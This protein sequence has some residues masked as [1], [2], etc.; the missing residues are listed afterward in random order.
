MVRTPTLLWTLLQRAAVITLEKP[1]ET[2]ATQTTQA[3]TPVKQTVNTRHST[4]P[5]AQRAED[6]RLF[7]ELSLQALREKGPMTVKGLCQYLDPAKYH[8]NEVHWILR[9]Y[10]RSGDL[11]REKKYD[12]EGEKLYFYGIN[13]EKDKG[14]KQTLPPRN[15]QRHAA[16]K[17][18]LNDGAQTLKTYGPD[19]KAALHPERKFG[20]L[21]GKIKTSPEFDAPMELVNSPGAGAADTGK[22]AGVSRVS[23]KVHAMLGGRLIETTMSDLRELYDDLKKIFGA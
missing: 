7:R 8:H 19:V 14:L 5:T 1:M 21:K 22:V 23:V 13:T 3:S 9:D 17:R 18:T 2:Q 12:D 15:P 4:A 20:A 11:V 10:V 16:K 6:L